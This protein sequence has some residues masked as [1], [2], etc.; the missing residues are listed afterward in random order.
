MA[1][2]A[3]E[4]LLAQSSDW[5]FIISDATATDYAARRFTEHADNLDRLLD[6]LEAPEL[7]VDAAGLAAGMQRRNDVFPEVM[8]ALR[9]A[10]DP[11]V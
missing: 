5:Q 10:L 2:A 4:L 8:A 3:R 7:P 9:S 11:A 1:Q 6:L